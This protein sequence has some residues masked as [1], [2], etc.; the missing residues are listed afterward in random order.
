MPWL[1]FLGVF[2]RHESRLSSDTTNQLVTSDR[3][4][5][6]AQ[7][8]SNPRTRACVSSPA[9]AARGLSRRVVAQGNIHTV[10]LGDVRAPCGLATLV[11]D[12][13]GLIG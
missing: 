3:R 6:R 4:A 10:A 7:Q 11:E 5:R 8:A 12:G 2:S 1:F 13:R 9:R